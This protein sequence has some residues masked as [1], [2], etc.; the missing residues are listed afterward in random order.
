MKKYIRA[1]ISEST[2][3]WLKKKLAT[4]R[5][6]NNLKNKMVNKYH[7]ALDR[8]TYTDEKTSSDC[9]PIYLLNVDYGTTVY[10]PGVNDDQSESING[11]YRKLGSIAKSK[12]PDMA[13]DI[14]YVDLGDSSNVAPTKERYQ[15]P[16]YTY[17]YS[18]PQGKYAG[19]YKKTRYDHETREEYDDGWSKSGMTPANES[20]ARDKSGYKIPSPEQRLA[21]YYK[22]FPDKI[23]SKVDSLYDK[24]ID[25]RQLLNE[26]DFNKPRADYWDRETVDIDYAK[27][28]RRFADAVD[29][30][31]K[32]LTNMK[33][34]GK[35]SRDYGISSYTRTI[36]DIS[37]R[38]DEIRKIL[39]GE[40]VW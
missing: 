9:I 33:D 13:E 37:T 15:D 29:D 14:V 19:Q 32:L 16:R 23:T 30:Y 4:D 26:A 28:Y 8:A 22:K 39:N 12:L 17:R 34:M 18:G 6:G 36:R 25:T 7:V 21:D 27:A 1:S 20:R 24:L 31:R 5:F 10:I 38:V 3:D 2:P 11:R 40:D 35:F